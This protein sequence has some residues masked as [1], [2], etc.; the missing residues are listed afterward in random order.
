MRAEAAQRCSA[1]RRRVRGALAPSLGTPPPGP[2]AAYAV[3]DL[4]RFRIDRQ[5]AVCWTPLQGSIRVQI[6]GTEAA[7]WSVDSCVDYL[8]APA[9]SLVST[10]KAVPCLLRAM[11][12]ADHVVCKG[13]S[14][15]H[16]CLRT[17]Y[18]HGGGCTWVL[19][20]P[21]HI[22]SAVT[23]TL[24]PAASGLQTL[25]FAMSD[26]MTGRQQRFLPPAASRYL[27][28]P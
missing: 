18:A 14:S 12:Y 7:G 24:S 11:A 5:V 4:A 25:R 23:A 13:Y 3:G 6:S 8:L 28:L 27:P 2:C 20:Q 9:L 17:T 16:F 1:A 21:G 10:G 26:V 19:P 22:P 15:M